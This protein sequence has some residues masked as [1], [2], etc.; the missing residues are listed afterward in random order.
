MASPDLN[1]AL[2]LRLVDQAT[3]P[4]RAVIG[5]LNGMGDAARDSGRANLAAAAERQRAL[6]QDA[7]AIGATAFAL[8]QALK[9]AINFETKMA[10]VGKVVDFQAPD[11]L[12]QLGR[13]IQSLVTDGALPMAADGIADIVAAAAQANLIDKSLPDEQVRQQLLSFADAA[14][15]MGIAFDISAEASGKAMAVWRSSLGLNQQQALELG[16]AVNHLSN[17]MNAGAADITDV[18]QRQGAVA[19]SAG[20]ATQEVA[21]LSAAL[22]SGGAGSEVAATAL[23]NFTGAL[24]VGEAATDR[25][26]GIFQKLGLDAVD[27][28]KRMQVDAKGAILDV[29]RALGQLDASERGSAVRQL[30]GEEVLGSV[31][32]L[33]DNIGTLETAF[34]LVADKSQYAGAMTQEYQVIAGTT[35]SRLVVMGNR[36]TELAVVLGTALLPMLIAAMEAVTPLAEAMASWSAANPEAIK[37]IGVLGAALFGLRAAI[38]VVSF[39]FNQLRVIWAALQLLFAVNPVVAAALAIGAAVYVIYREWDGIVAY[40]EAKIAAVKAAFNQGFGEGILAAV[41]EFNPFTL[42]L[43]GAA[44]FTGEI[45]KIMSEAFGIDLYGMGV[46]MIESLKAG[47]WSVLEAMVTAIRSRLTSIVPDWMQRA[48]DRAA[49]GEAAPAAATAPVPTEGVASPDAPGRALGGAVRAGQIYRWMEEGEEMFSPAVDGTVI[50]ARDVRAMRAPGRVAQNVTIGDIVIHAA[51]GMSAQ[52]VAR[53]VRDEL[54]RLT[55][56]QGGELHDGGAYA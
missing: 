52:D 14:G 2:V 47:I 23:K 27:L 45:L 36:A 34:G 10:E 48:W 20:L 38:F 40:F 8:T 16:D 11:G 56:A 46:A 21:A 55:R 24:T 30:F 41:A 49:G 15:K 42:I 6:N 9:P 33:V 28:S 22:L 25:Q 43:D 13:D 4:A 29:L 53:A 50:N 1:I 18:I 17:N 39:A 31:Q 3:R 19:K 7:L 51:A 44:G 32:P 37:T 5:A 35:A 12:Q 26:A 54:L